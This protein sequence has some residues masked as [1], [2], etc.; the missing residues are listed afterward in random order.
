MMESSYYEDSS[1]EEDEKVKR[2]KEKK[3]GKERKYQEKQKK[4][5][6]KYIEK[7]KNEPFPY[8]PERLVTG[9]FKKK[10]QKSLTLG[11]IDDIL[12]SEFPSEESNPFIIDDKG[13]IVE[14]NPKFEDT[15][16]TPDVMT[17]FHNFH[18]REATSII[19]QIIIFVVILI[20]MAVIIVNAIPSIQGKV[21]YYMI[22]IDRICLGIFIFE[23]AVNIIAFR[24][25]YFKS[26]SHILD[27]CIILLSIVET[28]ES[29]LAVVTKDTSQ[30]KTILLCF[31]G[32]RSLRIFRAMR[33]FN[34]ISSFKKTFQTALNASDLIISMLVLWFFSIHIFTIYAYIKF[35]DSQ[36]ENYGTFSVAFNTMFRCSMHAMWGEMAFANGGEAMHFMSIYIFVQYIVFFAIL[37]AI[38]TS[39]M[40]YHSQKLDEKK[41]M[42]KD[43]EVERI[44]R[45]QAD[46]FKQSTNYKRNT[47]PTPFYVKKENEIMSILEDAESMIFIQKEMERLVESVLDS[48]IEIMKLDD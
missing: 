22:I 9:K 17:V 20:N 23:C 14:I 32:L 3:E 36:P 33:I 38:I 35:K 25:H 30:L 45:K 43:K 39:S 1:I 15:D 42:K 6:D 41:L 46:L 8:K 5:L 27:F 11:Y 48:P 21:S 29:P 16:E 13:N 24:N 44:E 28:L 34:F 26:L 7:I 4:R 2:E 12:I 40:V 47:E 31:R 37:N 18:Y 10:K 19:F